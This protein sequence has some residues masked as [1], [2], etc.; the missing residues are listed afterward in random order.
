M[1]VKRQ[2]ARAFGLALE[3]R[4]AIWL[5]LKGHRILARNFRIPGGEIDIV[6]LSPERWMGGGYLCFVEVRGRGDAET[7]QGSVGGAKQNR[8]RAAARAYRAR[9]P[10]LAGFPIRFDIVAAGRNGALV[11]S[12]N[13]FDA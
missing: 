12:R 10:R 5:M 1:S 7:A 9:N 3:W 8:I 4:A 11:H 13:A 2:K 6:T